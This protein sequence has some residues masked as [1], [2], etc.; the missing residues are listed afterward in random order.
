MR[1]LLLAL[2]L[3]LILA[4]PAAAADLYVSTTG[5]D[6]AAGTQSAPLRSVGKALNLAAGGETIHVASGTYTKP[7][8]L[9]SIT[10]QDKK[11]HA[12]TVTVAGEPGTII[13][14]FRLETGSSNVRFQ[15]IEFTDTLSIFGA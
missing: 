1:S 9:G 14:G 13:Q 10:Y 7:T 4:S 2:S 15:G 5:S 6:L 12:A 11:P 3:A 8:N